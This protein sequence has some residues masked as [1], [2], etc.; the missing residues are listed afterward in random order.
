MSLGAGQAMPLIQYALKMAVGAGVT[1]VAAAG[2]DG[3]G[4]Q[5]AGG[6]SRPSRSRRSAR[7][8]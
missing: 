6:L 8:A 4:R 1:V 3:K 2:N 5:L 7:P